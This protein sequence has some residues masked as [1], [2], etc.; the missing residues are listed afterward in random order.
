[1]SQGPAS[2]PLWRCAMYDQS[3]KINPTENIRTANSNISVHTSIRAKVAIQTRS[4]INQRTTGPRQTNK[5]ANERHSRL[6]RRID[7]ID[8][9]S[10]LPLDMAGY[11]AAIEFLVTG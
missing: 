6:A 7:Q 9:T 1:M 5:Q 8:R 2:V 4:V 3:G 10:D 11:A